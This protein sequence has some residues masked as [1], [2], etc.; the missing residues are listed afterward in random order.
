MLDCQQFR[1]LIITPVL[2]DLQI[3]SRDAEELL[4]LTCAT[5]SLGGHYLTQV[6]GPAAGIYMMQPTTYTDLWIN[7]IRQRNQLATLMSLHLGCSRIPEIER[8]IYDLHFA[9]AMAR[10]HY[11]RVTEK[12]PPCTDPEAIYA[13]YKKYYNTSA[14]KATKADSLAKYQDFVKS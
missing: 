2:S 10:I 11:L 9:T 8:M 1:K 5:E 6:N 12:L 4:V 13:Y 3:Y 7:F 14:G